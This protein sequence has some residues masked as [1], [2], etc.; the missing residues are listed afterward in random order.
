M[1]RIERNEG[2]RWVG[3]EPEMST[4]K[5]A[6]MVAD[7]L[8]SAGGELRVIKVHT[9]IV[10]YHRC[11]GFGDCGGGDCQVELDGRHMSELEAEAELESARGSWLTADE[12]LGTGRVDHEQHVIEFLVEAE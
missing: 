3:L 8:S 7:A 6:Q 12:K 9:Y 11:G 2:G 5:G 1:F 4:T 10:R